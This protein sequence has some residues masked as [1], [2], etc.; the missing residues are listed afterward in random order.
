[1]LNFLHDAVTVKISKTVQER[2]V[3]QIEVFGRYRDMA[4]IEAKAIQ[5]ALEKQ[6]EY[7]VIIILPTI[8][9]CE[10]LKL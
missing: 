4:E 1:M 7:P 10:R 8:N 3:D 2:D 5:L 6:R 9:D